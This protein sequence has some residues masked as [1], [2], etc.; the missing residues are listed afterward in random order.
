LA[1]YKNKEMVEVEVTQLWYEEPPGKFHPYQ[2]LKKGGSRS[3]LRDHLIC[4]EVSCM[5]PPMTISVA[6]LVFHVFQKVCM[7]RA[8][9]SHGCLSAQDTDECVCSIYASPMER[10]LES[11]D[12]R[13]PLRHIKPLC[14]KFGI[15]VSVR[16]ELVL[17]CARS[18]HAP[19][20]AWLLSENPSAINCLDDKNRNILQIAARSPVRKCHIFPVPA[21]N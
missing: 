17:D 21:A 2:M 18:G 5:P 15:D 9:C 1:K 3:R 13:L 10:L 4:P 8:S 16:P 12:Q 19:A 11:I 6:A 20:L 14:S 7:K